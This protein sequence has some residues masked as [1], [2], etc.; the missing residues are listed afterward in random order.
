MRTPFAI[1]LFPAVLS[2]GPARG[3]AAAGIPPPFQAPPGK[4]L[5]PGYYIPRAF[6]ADPVTVECSDGYRVAADLIRRARMRQLRPGVVFIHESG[7]NK[8]SWFPLSIQ[9]A[10]RGYVVLAIDLRGCGE[11][12][13]LAGNP[14]T[15]EEGLKPEDY[16]KML[17]DVRNAISFLSMKSGVDQENMAIIGA[18]LGANLAICA[19]AQPWAKTVKCVIALSPRLEDHGYSAEKA[20]PNM[21]KCHLYIAASKGDAES[22]GDSLKLMELSKTTKELLS[23]EGAARG[24]RMFGVGILQQVP[25]WLM[26]SFT[27]GSTVPPTGKKAE[28]GR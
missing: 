20:V 27:P 26:D 4:F 8:R 25:L 6:E 24:V 18:G 21:G 19:A 16:A 17:E 28:K 13:G 3:D 23:G 14:K 7:R 12:P 5:A 1:L 22:Y 2:L 9:T 11:N 10:G 15:A